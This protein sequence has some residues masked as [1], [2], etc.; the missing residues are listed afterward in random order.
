MC[1]AV[2]SHTT[3]ANRRTKTGIENEDLIRLVQQR[4]YL[5]DC[6]DPRHKDTGKKNQGWQEI[7]KILFPEWDSL[8]PNVQ[9]DLLFALKTRWRS[10]RDTYTKYVKNLRESKSGSAASKKKPYAF[11]G[12]LAFLKPV[13]ELRNTESSWQEEEVMVPEDQVEAP[14]EEEIVDCSPL[15][16][17]PMEQSGPEEPFAAEASTAPI[18]SQSQQRSNRRSQT[19]RRAPLQEED[20]GTGQLISIVSGNFPTD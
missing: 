15:L 7:V 4:Q 3:M 6:R 5:W 2:Q 20:D 18:Q 13:L 1:C 11:A 12:Y 17:S 9:K 14:A 19:N 16:Q 8:T 10:L